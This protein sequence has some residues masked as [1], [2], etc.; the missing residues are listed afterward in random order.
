[1][2]AERDLKN[3]EEGASKHRELAKSI[4]AREGV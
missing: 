1:M 3:A 2:R 4:E